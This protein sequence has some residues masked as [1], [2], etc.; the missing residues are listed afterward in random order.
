[1]SQIKSGRPKSYSEKDLKELLSE[2]RK[3][4]QGTIAL[5]ALEKETGISRKTWKRRMGNV[6][7][8]LNQIITLQHSQVG[9]VELPLPN[10]DLIFDKFSDDPRGLRDAFFHLN[11]VIFKFYEEN[12][13]LQETVDKMNKQESKLNNII[14]TIEKTNHNRSNVVASNEKPME[15]SMNPSIRRSRGIKENLIKINKHNKESATSLEID[16]EFPELFNDIDKE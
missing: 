4:H 13:D 12:I 5:S 3:K 9:D 1:M 14:E 2:Y 8:E 11:E 15:E 6:I 16:K 10:V 7:E